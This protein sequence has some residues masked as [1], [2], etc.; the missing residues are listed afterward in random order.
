LL[1]SRRFCNEYCIFT[2]GEED[3]D[4]Y[5]QPGSLW[6]LVAGL[7]LDGCLPWVGLY[8]VCRMGALFEVAFGN[9]AEAFGRLVLSLDQ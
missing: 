6:R 7:R 3:F 8:G 2:V 5:F 1:V 9:M 4:D